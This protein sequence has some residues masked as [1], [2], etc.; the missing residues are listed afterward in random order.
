MAASSNYF[1][2]FLLLLAAFS[3]SSLVLAD[4]DLGGLLNSLSQG[5]VASLHES[6]QCMQKLLPCKTYLNVSA[7][8]PP[9]DT[10][11][12][13][14]Q[15]TVTDDFE[16]LC[17]FYNDPQIL[18]TL[19]ITRHDALQLPKACNVRL[20][21]SKCKHEASSPSPNPS[22]PIPIDKATTDAAAAA[23]VAAEKS[24]SGANASKDE[25]ATSSGTRSSTKTTTCF[26]VLLA[27][28]ASLFMNFLLF[29][30]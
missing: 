6:M 24:M 1:P 14:L 7:T 11:C 20:R 9:P 27:V 4:P 22:T 13:A 19:N 23:L 17:R 21:L 5:S 30:A 16:C 12:S 2:I 26:S 18:P 3:V 28:F 15:E 29:S 25:L 8:E 10:C